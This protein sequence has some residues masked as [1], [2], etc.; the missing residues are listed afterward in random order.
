MRKPGG[1]A[2]TGNVQ[3]G[4]HV[5]SGLRCRNSNASSDSPL[6]TG[7]SRRVALTPAGQRLIPYARAVLAAVQDVSDTA[8]DIRGL[9]TGSL[10]VATVTGMG[11]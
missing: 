11:A 7:S 2:K 9:L 6:S 5:L 4:A 1:W 10:R 3:A 8:N